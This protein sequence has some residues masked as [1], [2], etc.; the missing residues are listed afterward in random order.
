MVGDEAQSRLLHA[1]ADGVEE[2]QLPQRRGDH[3]LVGQPL[4]SGG[5]A[6]RGASD[7]ARAPVGHEIVDV[8]V[9]SP[10]RR[11][12]PSSCSSARA[13]RHCRGRLR[14]PDGFPRI[15]LSFHWLRYARAPS[16][17]PSSRMPT[18]PR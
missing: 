15:F 18:A 2:A 9:A 13:W 4:E 10:R 16:A 6:F 1:R 12:L 7:P 11:G 8:G 3:A 14:R 17:A 5:A